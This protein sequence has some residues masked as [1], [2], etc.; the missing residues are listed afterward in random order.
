MLFRSL[1]IGGVIGNISQIG[2]LLSPK[3]ITPKLSKI[4]PIKGFKN[5][6]SLKK[7]LDGLLITFKV[8]L[9]FVLGFIVFLTF[10]GDIRTVALL[11]LFQQMLWFREKALILIAV[12]LLLFFTFAAID[13]FVKRY[14]YFKSLRMGKK[15][16]KDEFKQH[17]GDP[18]VKARIRQIMM[19]ASRQKML[20]NTA[21]ADVVI[22]NP[23]HYAVAVELKM[24][25][26]GGRH[27]FVVAKGVDHLA[28]RI[29][30]VA[31]EHGIRVMESPQL[32]RDLYKSVDVD[33]DIPSHFFNAIIAVMQD[34]IIIIRR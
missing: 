6:V 9:A 15:E 29:K 27:P 21:K 18:E 17:E 23:T 31:L 12:L 19:K 30:S 22:T 13:F 7:L 5:V 20:V 1:V 25:G 26:D 16:V 2:L 8:L 34:L 14:Q 24:T 3:A 11:D 32:A 10:F 33:R 28:V 4:N